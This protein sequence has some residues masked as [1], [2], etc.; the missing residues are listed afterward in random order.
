MD[1]K[2]QAAPVPSVAQVNNNQRSVEL[3]VS[4]MNNMAGLKVVNVTYSATSIPMRQHQEVQ[5]A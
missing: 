1:N 2:T 5:S 3:A 4:S